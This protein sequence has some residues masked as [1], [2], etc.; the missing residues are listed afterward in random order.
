MKITSRILSRSLGLLLALTP[1][2]NAQ[3]D[4]QSALPEAEMTAEDAAAMKAHYDF[5]DSLSWVRSGTAQIGDRATIVI[6]EGYRFT[7]AE[8]STKLMDYYGNLTNGS[9]LGYISPE[10]MDW[11]AVFEFDDVGYVKEDEKDKLDADEILNQLQEGQKVANEQLREMGRPTLN[12]LGWHTPPFYNND[13][14][15]LEW[16]IRLSSEDGSEIINYKTKLLGRRGVMDV[17]LVCDEEQLGSVVPEYQNLLEGFSY[18]QEESYAAYTEGDKVAEYGL[19]GLIAGGGLLVA[20]KSGLLAKLWK[21]IA[22]GAIAVGSF[23]K[24]ILKGKNH[25]AI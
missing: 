25:D 24:R 21:P 13:T 19:I 23:L 20:A 18:N 12:V 4:D 6:P 5:I 15:N 1:L 17:V 22:I 8:G 11:F 14:K 10:N 7:G 9:E 16:A 2:A 3:N